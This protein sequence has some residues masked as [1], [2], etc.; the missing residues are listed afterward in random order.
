MTLR[1][2]RVMLD[3]DLVELYRVKAYAFLQAVK[4]MRAA[5]KELAL[6]GEK[7]SAFSAAPGPCPDRCVTSVKNRV[8]TT[9]GEKEK[10]RLLELGGRLGFGEHEIGKLRSIYKTIDS[11]IEV[12]GLDPLA[13]V[14]KFCLELDGIEHPKSVP[15]DRKTPR[16]LAREILKYGL[17]NVSNTVPTEK[18]GDH[19]VIQLSELSDKQLRD[20]VVIEDAP[21]CV[22]K[23]VGMLGLTRRQF[24]K[25]I[26]Q[27]RIRTYCRTATLSAKQLAKVVE[28][29]FGRECSTDNAKKAR[30]EILQLRGT[31]KQR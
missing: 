24:R 20:D 14:L 29:C 16:A 6:A 5:G 3:S 22:C 11:I 10:Q 7:C 1:A 15:L 18:N 26:E 23:T 12:A 13:R 9:A 8:A 25:L 17:I 30:A 4:T 27:P 21:A 19:H 31:N 2:Q 28:T